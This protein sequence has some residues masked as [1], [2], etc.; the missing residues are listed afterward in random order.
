MTRRDLIT[1]T[2]L[3]AVSYSRVPGANDRPSIA[4]IG[5]G[6]R[7]TCLQTEF[8]KLNNAPLRRCATCT[9]PGRKGPG[10]RA[11]G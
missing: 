4:L 11:G 10:R 3:T 2:A 7:G 9:A 1:S 5:C 6:A 8:Q